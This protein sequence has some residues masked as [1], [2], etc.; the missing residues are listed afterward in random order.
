[1]LLIKDCH[2]AEH[3]SSDRCLLCKSDGYLLAEV[4]SPQERANGQWLLSAY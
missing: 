3:L 4:G 2:G 1:M